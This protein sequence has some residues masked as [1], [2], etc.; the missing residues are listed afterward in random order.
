L[1][2]THPLPERKAGGKITGYMADG[3]HPLVD[4]HGLSGST[5]PWGSLAAIDFSRGEMSWK[6]PLGDY[7]L[8]LPV[9]PMLYLSQHVKKKTVRK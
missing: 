6:L 3:Y 2:C 5:P 8:A 1:R 7:P 4:E 9:L